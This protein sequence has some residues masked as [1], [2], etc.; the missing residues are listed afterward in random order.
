MY[1]IQVRKVYLLKTTPTKSLRPWFIIH[2]ASIQFSCSVVS[3]SLWPHELQHARLPCSS[4]APR[5][6]SNSCPLSRWC[7]PTISSSVV[8]FSSLFQSSQASVFFFFFFPKWIS[9]LHQVAKVLE[10][11]LQHQSFQWTLRTDLF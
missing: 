7:N 8:P 9:S 10:L 4:A 1:T 11:H 3:G 2:H 5:A 6:Y